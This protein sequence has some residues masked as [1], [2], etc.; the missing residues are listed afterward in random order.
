MA[1]QK[2]HQDF[3][4]NLFPFL[5]ERKDFCDWTILEDHTFLTA[6][7]LTSE[8]SAYLYGYNCRLS[9]ALFST[10]TTA[11]ICTRIWE[12]DSRSNKKLLEKRLSI[13]PKGA[14]WQM[15]WGC[16]LSEITP[17]IVEAVFKKRE[18]EFQEW[19]INNGVDI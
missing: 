5:R 13:N 1:I 11:R 14:T 19:C 7:A 12:K 8:W 15:I 9:F 10:G 17:E 18:N 3:Y 16:F 6:L 4:E 2:G